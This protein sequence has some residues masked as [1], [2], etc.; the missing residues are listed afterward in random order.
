MVELAVEQAL[1]SKGHKVE[2]EVRV[3][4]FPFIIDL[5]IISEDGRKYDIGTECKGERYYQD[6]PSTLTRE[7][8]RLKILQDEGW[9]IHHIQATE[10]YWH[11]EV[12]LERLEALLAKIRSNF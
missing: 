1:V 9:N 2:P 5:A 10:W 4:R 7:A 11:P 8:L 3:S 12:E 6:T